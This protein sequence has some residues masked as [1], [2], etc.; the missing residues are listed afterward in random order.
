[1]ASS[2]DYY[3]R[4]ISESVNASSLS[5]VQGRMAAIGEEARRINVA[6]AGMKEWAKDL[7]VSVSSLQQSM[8]NF[9][10]S[11]EAATVAHRAL[12]RELTGSV[13]QATKLESLFGRIAGRIGGAELL[14]KA[15]GIPG[16][17]FIGSQLM[18]GLGGSISGGA[19]M[20]LGAALGGA[21][22]VYGLDKLT[23]SMLKQAQALVNL[24]KET[25]DTIQHI[26]ILGEV[27]KITGVST[28][29][30]MVVV[31]DLSKTIVTGGEESKRMQQALSELGLN[32]GIAFE[33]PQR[34]LSD[35]MGALR[36]IPS[37]AERARLVV[38]MFGEAGRQLLPL[39]DS[40]KEVEA[41]AKASGAIIDSGLVQRLAD[42]KQ[43]S[44]ETSGSWATISANVAYWFGIM[45]EAAA[46]GFLRSAGV[47]PGGGAGGYP[48]YPVGR[49]VIDEQNRQAAGQMSKGAGMRRLY[50][51]EQSELGGG[52]AV[53]NAQAQVRSAESRLQSARTQYATTGEYSVTEMGPSGTSLIRP[54]TDIS[55]I[56]QLRTGV[57]TAKERVKSL[58]EAANRQREF[59]TFI[60]QPGVDSKDWATRGAEL[61]RKFGGTSIAGTQAYRDYLGRSFGGTLQAGHE[62]IVDYAQ[63][64]LAGGPDETAAKEQHRV[65]TEQESLRQK[66]TEL[67]A[68]EI[69]E[70]GKMA[71]SH[72]QGTGSAAEAQAKM[73]AA[74]AGG[75]STYGMSPEQRARR[76]AEQ[77]INVAL[78]GG[79]ARGALLQQQANQMYGTAGQLIAAGDPKAA[80]QQF[81]DAQDKEREARTAVTDAL[82]KSIDVVNKFNEGIDKAS[83]KVTQ[84]VAG[85]I[86]SVLMGAQRG[87]YK[88][89]GGQATLD[90]LRSIGEKLE[91]EFLT[92]I[93]K[94]EL[95][96][97]VDANGNPTGPITG[98]QKL[99]SKLPPWLTQGTVLQQMDEKMKIGQG[100]DTSRL[101]INVDTNISAMA[102]AYANLPGSGGG[103]AGGGPTSYGGFSI[104]TPF[105]MIS[106]PNLSALSAIASGAAAGA[107]AT[108]GSGGGVVSLGAW[109]G[110]NNDPIGVGAGS[111]GGMDANSAPATS[112]G[113]LTVGQALKLAG[114]GLAMYQGIS[115]AAKGGARNALSGSGEMLGGLAGLA[116]TLAAIAP[117]APYLAAAAAAVGFA[118]ALIPDPR[119]TRANQINKAIFTDTYLAPQA[120]NISEGGN[121]GYADVNFAGGVRT[122]GLSPFP[123]TAGGYLDVPRRTVVPGHTIGQ[124]GGY[125]GTP[126]AIVTPTAPSHITIVAM[127]SESF[128]QFA[129]RNGP[130]LA[131]GLHH[132]LNGG[133]ATELVST[134]GS[135]LG[136]R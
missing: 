17:G 123:Q 112:S 97:S 46:A 23:D 117:A 44:A 1:M 24:S 94:H 21:A 19:M 134:L 95:M 56:N 3:L 50:E 4:F 37:D 99:G 129:Q 16:G 91:S 131:N 9:A 47:T 87:A 41:A 88:G 79:V 124:F 7:G 45:R 73:G 118:A 100:I 49:E 98:L 10:G 109:I 40:F 34:Q 125:T 74:L 28:T 30:L 113:G 43:Y 14:G 27:S 96:G 77:E 130:A 61:V 20:G 63:K 81:K 66:T 12:N 84:E 75:Y 85:D 67:N 58:Q 5:E 65:Y 72:I 25:G 115:T 59:E 80:A 38:T 128:H 71:L 48:V 22:A 107:G 53:E 31:K 120:Q 82:T 86:T 83:E 116:S 133:Q 26:Q 55:G 54:Y 122:S 36:Q 119:T 104:P 35:L 114:V 52:T 93:A 60:A 106:L 33:A 8:K 127:D 132:A 13:E 110:S 64:L 121:A 69:E 70:Q 78:S 89:R 2:Q 6:N 101:M 42:L 11:T 76:Q 105:G 102:R 108:A 62:G 136:L 68:S 135:H 51:L 111:T 103:S 57:S 32:A 92:N 15:A 126:G 29:G 39:V 90:A 18:Y